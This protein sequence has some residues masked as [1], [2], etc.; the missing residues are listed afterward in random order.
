[1]KLIIF[2][3]ILFILLSAFDYYQHSFYIYDKNFL[4]KKFIEKVNRTI[5]KDN[6]WLYTTNIGN[7]KIK[8]NNNIDSELQLQ[9]LFEYMHQMFQYQYR[10][11]K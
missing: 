5:K 1:M 2:F 3:I 11:Q 8:H 9:Q 4:D 7:D 10:M 6:N